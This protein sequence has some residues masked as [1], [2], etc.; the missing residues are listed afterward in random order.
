[1]VLTTP[2]A[3]NTQRQFRVPSPIFR[4]DSAVSITFRGSPYTPAIHDNLII[5]NTIAID[6]EIIIT[7]F[8]KGATINGSVATPTQIPIAIMGMF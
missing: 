2:W 5:Q 8:N 4:V 1:M 6:G 3:A 7:A